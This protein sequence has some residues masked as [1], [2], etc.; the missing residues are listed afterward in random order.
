M[1]VGVGVVFM[2]IVLAMVIV[3]RS[4]G[5]QKT[6]IF[7]ELEKP[8][9][10]VPFVDPRDGHSDLEQMSAIRTL[11]QQVRDGTLDKTNLSGEE[12]KFLQMLTYAVN[13]KPP[14]SD[15]T[16]FLDLNMEERADILELMLDLNDGKIHPEEMDEQQMQIIGQLLIMIQKAQDMDFKK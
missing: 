14:S 4:S 11:L 10:S 6:S 9:K 15:K 2:F 3:G 13:G 1:V 8:D 12:K 16:R 5:S 7:A